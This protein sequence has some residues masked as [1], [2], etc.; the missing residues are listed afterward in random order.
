MFSIGDLSL[1]PLRVQV[2]SRIFMRPR[3]P[4]PMAKVVASIF[5]KIEMNC[6]GSFKE[7]KKNYTNRKN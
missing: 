2:T 7:D 6:F 5:I 3:V 4:Q 1:N